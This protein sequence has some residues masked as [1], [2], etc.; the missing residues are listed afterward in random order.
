M[1]DPDPVPDLDLAARPGR[2]AAKLRCSGRRQHRGSFLPRIAVRG[3]L[4]CLTRTPVGLGPPVTALATSSGVHR[5]PQ[6]GKRRARLAPC[7]PDRV[8]P[9]LAFGARS[10]A[11]PADTRVAMLVCLATTA[12]PKSGFT[13]AA[14][15]PS[16][17]G[18]FER[19]VKH[20]AGDYAHWPR[21]TFP[22]VGAPRPVSGCA[23]IIRIMFNGPRQPLRCAPRL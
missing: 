12:K 23:R 2:R 17:K 5:G 1:A 14:S 7:H 13:A 11:T 19:P 20:N 18:G 6:P 22:A 8:A 15:P 3:R 21:G 9:S 4:S 10:C 16:P